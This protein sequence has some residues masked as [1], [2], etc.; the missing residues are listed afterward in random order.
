MSNS[1]SS[2][3]MR[4]RPSGCCYYLGWIFF[5]L[6][7]VMPLFIPFLPM[8]GLN[9]T[10]TGILM[11]GFLV[12]GPELVMVIAVALWGKATFDYFMGRFYDLLKRLVPSDSVSTIRY[13]IG[14]ILLISSFFPSWLLAYFPML[15]SDALRFYIVFTFD[16]VFI[17]SFFV[18]GGDFWE[19]V[20]ALF[21][22]NS[23][24]INKRFKI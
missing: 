5:V 15:V 16:I 10:I 3:S 2:F 11:G 4:L 13:Y 6:S 20:R 23:I 18:L 19:K 7:F 24:T 22:P 8:L 17:I 14:L 12:G 1:P 9:Q 21:I